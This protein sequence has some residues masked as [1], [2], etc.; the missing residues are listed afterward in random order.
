MGRIKVTYNGET[1]VAGQQAVIAIALWSAVKPAPEFDESAVLRR[2]EE[3]R[4]QDRVYFEHRP[5]WFGFP[6]AFGVQ[7]D[8]G[9]ALS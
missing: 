3:I 7:K 1:I 5:G 2:L 8:D 4:E 6:P 9:L